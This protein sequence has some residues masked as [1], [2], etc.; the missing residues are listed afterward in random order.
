MILFEVR[1]STADCWVLCRLEGNSFSLRESCLLK[2]DRLASWENPRKEPCRSSIF[3]GAC[4]LSMA[5]GFEDEDPEP[6]AEAAAETDW[7]VDEEN[8]A[9]DMPA[10][11]PALGGGDKLFVLIVSVAVPTLKLPD[12]VKVDDFESNVMLTPHSFSRFCFRSRHTANAQ[13]TAWLSRSP[14]SRTKLSWN[15]FFV[16]VPQMSR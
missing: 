16:F 9:A 1:I 10:S 13:P 11:G 4:G 8:A 14:C 6:V 12:L 2:G 15:P 7:L 3:G 5:C